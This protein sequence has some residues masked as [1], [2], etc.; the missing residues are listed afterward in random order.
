MVSLKFIADGY[1]GVLGYGVMPALSM[2]KVAFKVTLIVAYFVTL[3]SACF[4]AF[5]LNY[6]VVGLVLGAAIG[7]AAQATLYWISICT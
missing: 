5:M 3:P 6:S 7:H 4:L 1:Q 2:Q